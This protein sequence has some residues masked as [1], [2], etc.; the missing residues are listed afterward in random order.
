MET[1]LGTLTFVHGRQVRRPILLAVLIALVAVVTAVRSDVAHANHCTG[2]AFIWQ[3]DTGNDKWYGSGGPGDTNWGRQPRPA[4]RTTS[5][6]TGLG[7]PEQ[8]QPTRAAIGRSLRSSP[9][10]RC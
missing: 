2:D 10:P 1:V 8:G 7:S 5:A 3:G 6:S 9:R 4:P